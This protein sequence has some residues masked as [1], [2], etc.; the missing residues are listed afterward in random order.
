MAPQAKRQ[1]TGPAS[2]ASQPIIFQS[3]GLQP[4][5]RL[6][7]FHTEFHVHS[8][9]LKLH[10]AFFRKFLD[11]PDKA[12]AVDQVV[13]RSVAAPASITPTRFKYEWITEIEAEGT[14]HL[15]AAR[16]GQ[17]EPLDPSA[18]KSRKD[19]KNDMGV[20]EKLL[21]AIYLQPYSISNRGELEDLVES[22]DY[23]CALPVLSRTLDAA[24]LRSPHF[25]S[26]I[27]LYPCSTLV[28]A[29][30]LRNAVLFRESM[31]WISGA[32]SGSHNTSKMLEDLKDY[33]K[34]QKIARNVRDDL[35]NKV[36]ESQ[37]NLHRISMK[38]SGER[39]DSM[40]KDAAYS[41]CIDEDGHDSGHFSLPRYFRY[42]YERTSDALESDEPEEPDVDV[43]NLASK[44]LE[45]K[46]LLKSHSL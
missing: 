5:V 29:A 1:K 3:P 19:M 14:W 20:F 45:N 34:L 24:F 26:E 32:I 8:V 12:P 2:P 4:D 25:V 15:I 40:L 38:H 44:V 13:N 27:R 16:Y 41:T 17:N 36:L 22:A 39:L 23:H 35:S 11:S 9:L 37:T 10:S 43:A 21:S 30:K 28:L 7:V 42:L 18:L 33:P 6:T 46:L 31:I